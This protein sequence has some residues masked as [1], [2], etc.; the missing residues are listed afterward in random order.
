MAFVW[1]LTS[2]VT[3]KE[4]NTP[5]KTF[6]AP[7]VGGKFVRS[8]MNGLDVRYMT[9]RSP[10]TLNELRERM[11]LACIKNTFQEVEQSLLGVTQGDASSFMGILDDNGW[12]SKGGMLRCK[13]APAKTLISETNEDG[14]V[15][16]TVVWSFESEARVVQSFYDKGQ[17]GVQN[18][19]G[20]S[21]D[22]EPDPRAK[23][24]MRF[25]LEGGMT[26]MRY[27]LGDRDWQ[28]FLVSQFPPKDG[29][30]PLPMSAPDQKGTVQNAGTLIKNTGEQLWYVLDGRIITVVIDSRK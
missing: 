8:K 20:L 2:P 21:A 27:D 25:E 22:V 14:L 5:S 1:R 9:G 11:Q 7:F 30:P 18:L 19:Q 26:L 12:D 24:L 28:Q 6:P 3:S 10:L 15:E 4:Q 23:L 17:A 29:W 13:D 16:M